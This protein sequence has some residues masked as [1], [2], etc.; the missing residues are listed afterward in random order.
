MNDT[1]VKGVSLSSDSPNQTPAWIVPL[2]GLVCGLSF[3]LNLVGQTHFVDESAYVSQAYFGD[4]FITGQYHSSL[5]FEYPA[6]DLPPFT[7]YLVWSGLVAGGD[8]RPGPAAMRAWYQNTASRFETGDMLVHARRPIALCGMFAVIATGLL[9]HRWRG[10]SAAILAMILLTINPLFR[11]HARRAM[12]DVPTE[13]GVVIGL[14][15][16]TAST[17]GRWR[18]VR[19]VLLGGLFLGIAASSKLNGLLGSIVIAI[20][21]IAQ[22]ARRPSLTALTVLAG[23]VGA[24]VFIGLNP[25]FYA[26]ANGLKEPQFEKFRRM[27]LVDRLIFMA[28]HR[29]TVSREGQKLFPHD[30]LTSV[31]QK[32]AALVVQGFGRFSPI[33]PRVDD[34][35]TRFQFKQDWS[36][37]VWLPLVVAGIAQALRDRSERLSSGRFI[38]VYWACSVLVVGAFLPLAWNRYYLP[39]V[40]P[41]TVLA[42]G[43]IVAIMKKIG[44]KCRPQKQG[45]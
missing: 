37:L 35:R 9:A 15:I 20:W 41:S 10:P 6:Y 24:S 7:K 14:L 36:V 16:L 29:V 32:A 38:V 19:K 22:I 18:A 5:W 31:P 45:A 34:S 40:I 21:A 11:T 2:V 12:A 3:F 42:A 44:Q 17:T 39:L 27:G 23:L 26:Q 13:M 4:L 1:S 25:F 30:A 8:A 33:G 43:A 28:E